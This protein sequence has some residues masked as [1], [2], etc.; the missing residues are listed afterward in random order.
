MP[1]IA[2]RQL[3]EQQSRITKNIKLKQYRH[4]AYEGPSYKIIIMSSAR[5]KHVEELHLNRG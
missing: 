5:I 4:S 1:V 3:A 2:I